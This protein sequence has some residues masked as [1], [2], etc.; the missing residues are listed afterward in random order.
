MWWYY[1]VAVPAALLLT[2][3]IPHFTQGIAGRSFTTPFVGGPPRL[4]SAVNNVLWGG[5]NLI[6]GGILLWLIWP[7]MGDWLLLAELVIVSIAFAAFLA[8]LFE[9]PE[10]F[11][12]GAR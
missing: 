4:D 7:G 5:G 9:H 2:N 12:R 1:L 3:G 6:A 11:G 8:S 10:R